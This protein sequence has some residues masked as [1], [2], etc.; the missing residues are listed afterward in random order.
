MGKFAVVIGTSNH[1]PEGS[2]QTLFEETYQVCWRPWL[3]TLYR[4]PEISSAVHY[5]GTVLAWLHSHHPEFIMLL[6]EMSSRKQVEAIGGGYFAPIMPIIPSPDR[7]GQLEFL[8]TL[9][10]KLLG[11]RPR[12]AWPQDFAWE[13]SLVSTYSACG[14]DFSFLP[15]DLFR[16]SGLDPSYPV[17]TEDQGKSLCIFPVIGSDQAGAG[18]I[19]LGGI[20]GAH[21]EGM[22]ETAVGALM[23]SDTA[24]VKLWRNSDFESPDVL[25]E[26][27]FASLRRDG[28]PWETILPSRWMRSMKDPP[29]GYF[30]CSCSPRLASASSGPDRS[31]KA[32]NDGILATSRRLLLRHPESHAL[33]A[34]MQ[35]V[36]I[37]VGQLRGDKSRKKSAQE[38]VWR[39]Q[40]GDAYWEGEAGGI[41][42]LSIRAAAWSALIEAERSTR[43]KG[44]FVPGII[45]ADIDMDG[46]K[47]ILFQGVNYNAHVRLGEASLA[48]FDS[49]KSLTNYVNAMDGER[50]ADRLECFVDRLC[51]SGAFLPVA[52][53]RQRAAYTLLDGGKPSMTASFSRAPLDVPGTGLSGIVVGKIYSFRRENLGVAWT[54]ADEKGAGAR[55]RFATELNL[56][57]GRLAGDVSLRISDVAIRADES[58]G[59]ETISAFSI[60]NSATLERLDFRSDRPFAFELLPLFRR[61]TRDGSSASEWQG[62]RIW[63]GWDLALEPGAI[64]S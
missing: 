24:L 40:C 36:R 23:L 19:D 17:M 53:E 30:P 22:D 14:F 43:Q 4:F 33:Y 1:L 15:V 56:S 55:F 49:F 54:L 64:E 12:G 31:G 34:K 47:E 60:E 45:R 26:T 9:I 41:L 50:P 25:F 27:M 32:S 35:F 8:S 3:S 57:A 52:K 5:S 51:E 48:E 38:E 61:V 10:R 6:E 28:D 7:V 59:Q 44:S 39:A 63:I 46:Q 18:L 21:F 29:R 42:S 20:L 2:P 62:M 58:A 16:L 37:L 11:K 13:P